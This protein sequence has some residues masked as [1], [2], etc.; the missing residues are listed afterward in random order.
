MKEG[1]TKTMTLED[2]TPVAFGQFVRW[3]YTRHLNEYDGS[4]LSVETLI[5]LWLLADKAMVPKLQ[6]EAIWA[7]NNHVDLRVTFNIKIVRKYGENK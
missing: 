1:L 6:N 5:D 7:I 3:C 2:A 4:E